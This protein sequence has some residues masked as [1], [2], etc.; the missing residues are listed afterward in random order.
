MISGRKKDITIE[1]EEMHFGFG[2]SK[3]IFKFML[4]GLQ[5]FSKQ[6]ELQYC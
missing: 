2:N 1:S 4:Y 3:K 6:H 5:E